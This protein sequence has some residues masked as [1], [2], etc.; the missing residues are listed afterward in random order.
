[1]KLKLWNTV[2]NY[3]CHNDVNKN[4]KKHYWRKKNSLAFFRKPWFPKIHELKSF[5]V[6]KSIKVTFFRSLY[7]DHSI[8]FVFGQ[9]V[10]FYPNKLLLL[11]YLNVYYYLPQNVAIS[12]WFDY[13][14]KYNAEV[15][16]TRFKISP[17]S[18][19]LRHV[20]LQ[21]RKYL[22]RI[23]LVLI[24]LLFFSFHLFLL[25]LPKIDTIQWG[26]WCYAA[27]QD[28]VMRPIGSTWIRFLNTKKK[29][30]H[31]TGGH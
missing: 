7:S 9:F 18:N 12:K 22:V 25:K 13:Y 11:L 27:G 2:L 4:R 10:V 1:M 31:S 30:I 23:F 26:L 19:Y 3:V 6:E 24:F 29:K 8:L 16:K 15:F 17:I 28:Q 20:P 14:I 5:T 21:M